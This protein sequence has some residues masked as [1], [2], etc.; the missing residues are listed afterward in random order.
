MAAH[1]QL[2][3]KGE[4]LA[5]TYLQER[6]YRIMFKN[7]RFSYFEIDIIAIKN[8]TLHFIEVKT[9]SNDLGGLPEDKVNR[10]KF[11]R[12]RQ[13]ADEFIQQYPGHAWIQFDILAI[14][15]HPFQP[16]QYFLIE[17]IYLYPNDPRE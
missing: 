13:A 14:I 15:C 4:N 2:G 7:W 5:A 1:N 12:I 17:D 9:R 3:K 6:G 10:K 11:S 8:Q 16:P